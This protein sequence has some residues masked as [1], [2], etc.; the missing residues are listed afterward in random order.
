[1]RNT[2][3]IVFINKLDRPAKDS[4]DLLDEIENELDIHVKPLSWPIGDGPH[5]KG[6][7]DLYREKLHLFSGREKQKVEEGMEFSNLDDKELE[8]SIGEDFADR[9]REDVELIQG[10]YPEFDNQQYLEG[11]VAPVFFGSALNNFGV[12]ELLECFLDISPAPQPTSAEERKVSPEEEKFSGFVFKIHANMDPNHRDRIAFVKVCSGKFYRNTN[13][14]HVRVGKKMKFSSPTSFMAAR[15]SVIDEAYPGDIVGIHD[16]GNFKIGDTLT[17]GEDIHFRGL[18]SFSPEMFRYVENDDPMRY[19]QLDKGIEQL[20]DEGVA[21]LFKSKFNGRKII[22]T[23]GQ[24]QLDVIQFRLKN[25]YG[26][27]CRYEN[28]PMY[29]ACWIESEDQEELEDFR[30]RKQQALA[31]DKHGREVF[32]AESAHSLKMAQ[33]KFPNIKFHFS[34]EF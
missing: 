22:G 18:P 20:M 2:P 26:A 27:S 25:E 7:Y 6:V 31:L 30:R 3:V 12:R 11:H 8:N 24:L 15:K 29:K 21:Q 28:L 4:F 1:M 16:T 10:V 5:F 19:K 33:E 32:L 17:E 23:V 14:K 34:S 9:L 13:Y